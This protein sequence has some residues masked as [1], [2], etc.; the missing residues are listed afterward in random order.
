M[1]KFLIFL[2]IF[3]QLPS[4]CL[5][6]DITVVQRIISIMQFNELDIFYPNVK[7]ADS[8]VHTFLYK[9]K[10][11]KSSLTK[12]YDVSF[13]SEKVI[14]NKYNCI[15]FLINE[16]MNN[17]FHLMQQK[18]I[19]LRKPCWV[20]NFLRK[21]PKHPPIKI[22]QQ[23]Y[24]VQP[25]MTESK[26]IKIIEPYEIN[27]VKTKNIHVL[28]PQKLIIEKLMED[29]PIRRSEYCHCPFSPQIPDTRIQTSKSPRVPRSVR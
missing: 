13:A 3:L 26:A 15:M 5:G 16:T 25:N 24:I 21:V 2:S 11:F 6:L 28:K 27:Q 29:F 8:L 22:G 19:G 23:I 7:S 14:F 1:E 9:S 17:T 20:F 4:I 18:R 12:V 10:I